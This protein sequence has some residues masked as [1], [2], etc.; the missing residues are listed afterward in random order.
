MSKDFIIWTTNSSSAYE[1]YGEALE[2]MN[3]KVAKY[4][5]N[6]Y[7]PAEP[8]EIGMD[9]VEWFMCGDEPEKDLIQIASVTIGKGVT[10]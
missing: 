6:P 7:P 1:T 3:E 9:V 8:I 5:R 2:A 10:A 4:E